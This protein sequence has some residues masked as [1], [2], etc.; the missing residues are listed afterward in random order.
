MLKRPKEY[1]ISPQLRSARSKPRPWSLTEISMVSPARRL[2]A[3][4]ASV[5]PAC[6]TTFVSSS[7]I[8]WKSSAR[9]LSC[10]GSAAAYAVTATFS[11]VIARRL[12]AN[13]RTAAANP[14]E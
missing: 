5:T 9:K 6:L 8:D 13:Q 12:P 14:C 2:I 3:T 10:A 11:P 7:R 4:P 1:E